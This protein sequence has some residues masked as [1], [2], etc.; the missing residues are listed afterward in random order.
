MS[1]STFLRQ[2]CQSKPIGTLVNQ[3]FLRE[4]LNS[5]SQY[6][7]S[8]TVKFFVPVSLPS[9]MVPVFDQ[10]RAVES[11]ILKLVWAKD[12]TGANWQEVRFCACY[13]KLTYKYKIKYIRLN[14]PK[15]CDSPRLPQSGSN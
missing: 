11:E 4:A 12:L 14:E 1:K 3:V 8:L 15:Y 9:P 2:P 7:S 5:K 13:A 10:R 6:L